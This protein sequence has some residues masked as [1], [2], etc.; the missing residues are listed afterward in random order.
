MPYDTRGYYGRDGDGPERF[1]PATWIQR[2]LCSKEPYP[3]DDNEIDFVVCSH[4]LEDVRDPIWVCE[5][6]NRIGKG[7]YIEVPSRLEEQS[8]GVQG[9]W[10]G[11]GHHHWL[12]DI[13]GTQMQFTFKHHIIHGRKTDH[14][15][16]SFWAGLGD[17]DRVQTMWWEGSFDFGEQIFIGPGEVDTYL[18]SFVS[19]HLLGWKAPTRPPLAQRA[20]RRLRAVIGHYGNRRT[21]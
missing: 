16:T 14:F 8:Y 3:F 10:V 4:T 12:V 13:D 18:A 7:G 2:D 6:I 21:C 19:G 17:E 1:S 5:E 20:A 15:P 11:W 9:T